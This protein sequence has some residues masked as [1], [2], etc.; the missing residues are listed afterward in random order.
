M[1]DR[2]GRVEADRYTPRAMEGRLLLKNCSIYRA[3]GR[4]RTEM[5]VVV[6]GGLVTRVA[7]DAE[8]PVLPGD[9]EVACR[10]RMVAP[11]LVDCHTHLVGAQLT[12]LSGAF[13]L[14]N[15]RARFEL[16]SSLAL[17]LTRGE[18]EALTAFAIAR[19][20]RGGVT[21]LV[22]HL[23]APSDVEGALVAQ[24]RVAEKLGQPDPE[25]NFVSESNNFAPQAAHR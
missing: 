13:L 3:D 14:R 18:V 5:V 17:L 19:A 2:P 20:L 12:P 22:E 9:W 15:A 16:Q 10:G 23:Q 8:V 1:E 21:L 6:E 24:A 4:I 25:S 11:G 7:P